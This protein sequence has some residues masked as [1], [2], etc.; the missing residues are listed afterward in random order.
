M[1]RGVIFSLKLPDTVAASLQIGVQPQRAAPAPS[2]KTRNRLTHS[3]HGNSTDASRKRDLSAGIRA[4][5]RNL[6]PKL[7]KKK[8]LRIGQEP[9][10]LAVNKR[11]HMPDPNDPNDHEW[12]PQPPVRS[13]RSST[14]SV[15][16]QTT[17]SKAMLLSDTKITHAAMQQLQMD[18][19]FSDRQMLL[20]A[21]FI[22][23]QTHRRDIIETLFEARLSARRKDIDS[24][25]TATTIVERIPLAPKPMIICNDVLKLIKFIADCHG[26]DVRSV[27]H[28]VDAGKG[29]LKFNLTLEFETEEKNS[30]ISDQ[31]RYRVILVAIAPGVSESN[32]VFHEV[33]NRIRL[34]TNQFFHSWHADLKAIA[35]GTGI[36]QASSS[37]P[38]PFCEVEITV[39]RSITQQMTSSKMRTCATNRRHYKSFKRSKAA[40][41]SRD[42][43]SCIED[44]LAL[45]PQS[46]EIITWCRLPQLHLHLHLNWYIEAMERRLPAVRR[47][48]LEYNQTKADFHGQQFQGPQLQRLTKP[49]SLKSLHK[50]LMQE[51]ADNDVW[52]FYNAMIA[53]VELKKRCF[54]LKISEDSYVAQLRDFKTACSVLPIKKIPL[55]M[56]ILISHLDRSL[57]ETRRGLGADSEQAFEGAHHDFDIMWGRYRVR[58]E[59][60][61]V[62]SDNLR[63]A[64]VNF[65]TSHIPI[66]P[67]PNSA[68]T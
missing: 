56:H 62:Y 35:Y 54:G 47:W 50:L 14:A 36:E 57:R 65:N 61:A 19:S 9:P 18:G 16:T 43:K 38:C 6:I 23:T 10:Q 4:Q 31:A 59:K 33:Y 66:R 45:F 53:F 27:H 28:G 11:R 41:A 20:L 30:K 60:S 52:L 37:F 8:R 44:P 22:R 51:R 2:N 15:S 55:K 29:F 39:R 34:P 63:R 67:N 46:T 24:L 40:T 3:L 12:K 68:D 25:F 1:E 32:S 21:K 17:A 5:R 58:H 42:N 49:D 26:R 64:T 13:R 7:K 48:Y